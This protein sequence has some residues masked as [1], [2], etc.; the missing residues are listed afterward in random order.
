MR[1]SMLCS[2][3]A[4]RSEASLLRL[5]LPTHS[6]TRGWV[7]CGGETE[8]RGSSVATTCTCAVRILLLLHVGNLSATR[9]HCRV[10][11]LEDRCALIKVEP[12]HQMTS[13]P[14]RLLA[15]CTIDKYRD[16]NWDGVSGP[17]RIDLKS[18]SHLGRNSSLIITRDHV[19]LVTL[20]SLLSQS[21]RGRGLHC[22]FLDSPHVDCAGLRLV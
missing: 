19:D 13:R 16:G 2:G 3:R 22:T 7:L 9:V 15:L 11:L 21:S 17:T 4:R 10:A 20:Y 6:R 8:P 14:H 5:W 1:G 18:T 12:H